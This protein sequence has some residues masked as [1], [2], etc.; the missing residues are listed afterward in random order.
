MERIF[1]YLFHLNPGTADY[2]SSKAMVLL[3]ICLFLVITGLVIRFIRSRSEDKM[4]KKLSAGWPAAGYWFG[5]TGLFLIICRVE[6]IAF[7]AMRFWWLIWLVILA[8][9]IFF[10]WKLFKMRYYQK[11]KVEKKTDPRELYLPRRKN[12][13]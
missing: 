13:I 8:V 1:Y 2:A 4:F 7:F 12:R 10:Q 5:G 6:Q 9:Y 3:I 11:I